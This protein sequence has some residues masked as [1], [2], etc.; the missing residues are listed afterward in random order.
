[1]YVNIDNKM[2]RYVD[3]H[4][5]QGGISMAKSKSSS[6]NSGKGCSNGVIIFII[7]CIIGLIS[8][9]GSDRDTIQDNTSESQSECSPVTEM[10]W[11]QGNVY[12][13]DS[14]NYSVRL[15]VNDD[16]IQT[17][18]IS[19]SLFEINN[20]NESVCFVQYSS[21]DSSYVT[22]DITPKRDGLS[23]IT[24]TYDGVTTDELNVTVSAETTTTTTTKTT[25]ATETTTTTEPT[26][27]T[28]KPTTTITE[29][30]T[31]AFIRKYVINWDSYIVHSPTC[32]TLSDVYPDYYEYVENLDIDWAEQ[33]GLRACKVCKPIWHN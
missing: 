25:T 13:T 1:M 17:D 9:C 23:T 31:T 4:D 11:E 27:T 14:E 33:E 8:Q 28:T 24:I 32:R 20:S 2:F 5:I 10:H 3:L 12:I 15:K 16:T 19:P 29:I 7:I 21:A 22:F 26:T 18:G 6:K 30:T